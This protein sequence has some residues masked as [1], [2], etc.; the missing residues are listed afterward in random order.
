M[1]NEKTK[2]TEGPWTLGDENNQC[3][4]VT[5]GRTSVSID[6]A[7]MHTGE[8]GVVSRAEMLANAALIAAAPDLLAVARSFLDVMEA[9]GFECTC[10]DGDPCPLC[11]T[12]AAIARAE[13]RS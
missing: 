10:A 9:D 13:G 11:R 1:S 2:H 12:K 4:D 7:D 8:F 5:V 6:R 3:C